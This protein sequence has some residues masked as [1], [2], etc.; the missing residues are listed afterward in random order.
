MSCGVLIAA[1]TNQPVYIYV[2]VDD[3]LVRSVGKSRIPM[4]AVVEH[5][6]NLKGTDTSQKTSYPRRYPQS[7][8]HRC[9]TSQRYAAL[10]PPQREDSG[11]RVNLTAYRLLWFM[12]CVTNSYDQGQH[13][14]DEAP[15]SENRP[16]GSGF[17][18]L[19]A[20]WF[21]CP[22]KMHNNKLRKCCVESMIY[23]ATAI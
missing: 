1:S 2:D 4:A 19:K 5:V 8:P 20:I 23:K 12:F 17:V 11:S 21:Y 9:A 18:I 22:K 10:H 3:T 15:T 13:E 14:A 16:S 7:H 6:R